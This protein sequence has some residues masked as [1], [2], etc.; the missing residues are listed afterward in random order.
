MGVSWLRV[1]TDR[2]AKYTQ[3]GSSG[4][5][6]VSDGVTAMD[7]VQSGGGAVSL[8]TLAT[9][10]SRHPEGELSADKDYACDL[11][12]EG[13]GN[14]CIP[15]GHRTE[16]ATFDQEGGLLV[17]GTAP[18]VVVD[19]DGESLVYSGGETSDCET[20]QG[21]VF[22]L[23]GRVNDTLLAGGTMNNPGDEDFDAAVKSGTIYRLGTD[24]L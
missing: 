11:L 23:A 20:N 4:T 17:N 13:G 10:N 7:I 1:A 6:S 22:T 9:V 8:S 21:D 24:G 15:K 3:C 16:K 18:A 19:E 5:L 2:V 14:L 12:L